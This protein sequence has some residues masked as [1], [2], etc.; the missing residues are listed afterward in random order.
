MKKTLIAAVVAAIALSG[1]AWTEAGRARQAAT[2]SDKDADITCWSYGTETFSG[3]STGKV[4]YEDGGRVS[5]VDAGNG[6]YTSLEG[7][8]RI[9]YD[10]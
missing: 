9:V 8:C 2:F 6:R 10:L 5:F 3:R 4:S 7:D 1:C